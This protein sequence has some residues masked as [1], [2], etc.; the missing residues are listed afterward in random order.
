MISYVGR[1]LTILVPIVALLA[2]SALSALSTS[3]RSLTSSMSSLATT[4]YLDCSAV[5]EGQGT[6]ESPWK[7][8][9]TVNTFTFHPGDHLLIKRGTTCEGTLAPKGS[10][11][12]NDPIVIDSYA[13]GALPV[14]KGSAGEVLK[15]FNQQYWEINHLEIV[16]GQRYG[17]HVSGDKPDSILHHIYLR[18][19]DV[20]GATFSSTRRADSGEVFLSPDGANQTFEDVLID[21]VTAHDSHVSE[22]IF[23]S[24]GGKWIE[25]GNISQPLGSNVTVEDSTAHDVYGDGI[26]LAE[27]TNGLLQ[28]NVVYK[29]GLCPGCTGSTPVGLWEWYCHTCT[30]QFNE[31]YA[32][33]SWDGDG[34]DFDIDYYNDNNIVQYNYG[35]D[36]AGYCIAVFGS[37]GR[38]SH[39][40]VFR[41]N[42]CA[43]DGRRRDLSKTGEVYIYT[44]NDGSIDGIE[45]Y[46]NTIFWNPALNAPAL[47]AGDAR[48]TGNGQ[49]IFKN[50]IIYSTVP[51]MIQATSA[52]DLDNNIYWTTS[53]SS[54]RWQLDGRMYTSF[55]DYQ[56]ATKQDG[57]GFYKDPKMTDPTYHAPGKPAVAFRLLPGSPASG[58]G[59]NVCRGISECS[60]GAR[61]F[62]GNEIPSQGEYNIGSD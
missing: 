55:S 31:S 41:Y 44:W 18:G 11:A 15:L 62:F 60:M 58:T 26:L 51:E 1:S 36:S 6:K 39:N 28:G 46:N 7:S 57:R 38:A 43:N 12:Q 29:S 24:A 40:N 14:I 23:V 22:G 9:P 27:V 5:S 4:Y 50:N 42:I 10:G 30:V 32:N 52:L 20:H 37:G 25:T 49:R 54:P 35:H 34:G 33:Q 47:S 17:V 56:A 8:L 61:N 59:A 45:I 21:G 2:F 19:L 16:G 3:D 13:T 53:Q 48:Y